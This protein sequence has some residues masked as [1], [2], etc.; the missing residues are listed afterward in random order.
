VEFVDFDLLE[1]GFAFLLVIALIALPLASILTLVFIR[2]FRR[3][4]EQS[5]RAAANATTV[6]M[7][8]P[9]SGGLPGELVIEQID[10]AGRRAEA[11]RAVPLLGE[12]RRHSWELAAIYAGA[13]LVYPL[14]LAP[15]IILGID[16]APEQHVLLKFALLFGLFFTENATPAVLAP[17]LALKKQ[18]RFMVLAVLVLI[19]E[20]ADGRD[21]DLQRAT[22][23]RGRSPHFRRYTALPFGVVTGL[24]YAALYALD[25]A[26]PIRFVRE[27][28]AQLSL[29]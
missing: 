20:C 29:L 10:A 13:T 5:M 1:L 11:A 8:P 25:A 6:E 23:A 22:P 19:R 2:R 18:A 3:R 7:P 27:D 14:V 21:P 9:L 16:F 24:A 12:T 28:L 15:V 26:G 17:T 4:V